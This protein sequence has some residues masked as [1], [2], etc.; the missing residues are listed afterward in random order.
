ML[1][2]KKVKLRAILKDDL[3]ALHDMYNDPAVITFLDTKGDV[4]LAS[5]EAKLE[6]HYE[7]GNKNSEWLV[8]ENE[9]SKV[10]GSVFYN[11]KW[12]KTLAFIENLYVG[13]EYRNRGFAT[14]AIKL[15]C[16]FLFEEREFKRIEVLI[17]E[18]SAP[19]LRVFEKT[20]FKIEGVRRKS[21]YSK[22]KYLDE[23]FMS[24]LDHEYFR[25]K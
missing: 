20:G 15:L 23:I 3:E 10:T 9:E 24:L 6:S 18:D 17:R 7:A 16:K 22:G 21:A 19:A 5:F 1:V 11:S 14:D 4:S 12:R 2:G 25:R 8:L 13:K